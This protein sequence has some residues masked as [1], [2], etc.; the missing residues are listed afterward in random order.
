V[1]ILL[2]HNRYLQPGGEDEI[3]AAE[4]ALLR[5][6]GQAVVEYVED[7]RSIQGL[8]R[9]QAAGR[10]LWSRRARKRIRRLLERHRPQVA[11]FHNTFPLISP[12][13]YYACQA[14]GTPVIQT[15]HNYRLLC[16]G[17]DLFRKGGSCE[18]CLGRA[19]PWAGVL[20]RCYRDSAA[21]SAVVSAMLGLHNLLGTWERQVDL[22]V[23]LSEFARGK[24]I[25]GGL[26]EARVVVKPNFVD[27]DPGAGAG[28][29]GYVLFAGRLSEEKGL[30][31]LLRAWRRL[32]TIPLRIAGNGPLLGFAQDFAASA[33][34]EVRVLGRRSRPELFQLMKAARFLVFPSR[35]Y[36]N[37]PMVIAEAFACGLPVV[38]SGLGAAAE[39]VDHG[40]TG[41][42]VRP[43][44]AGALAEAVAWL[45][46]HPGA[47]RRM[48][49]EARLDFENRYSAQN[50]YARMMEIYES[51][52]RVR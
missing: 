48:G 38:A 9:W 13:A 31:T 22:F 3:F 21:Q 11:H 16:A 30:A 36:E 34:A 33:R 17:A 2:A 6:Q 39:I 28:D 14:A 43:G 47:G 24:F 40:R 1:K 49:R 32:P 50:S 12:A 42:L 44:H 8:G 35:C 18:L 10:A 52:G 25:Q 4:A 15:L 19:V 23:A 26:P 51:V 46:S 20:H 41:M 27:P 45:W 29:G 37:F 7:N 5:R